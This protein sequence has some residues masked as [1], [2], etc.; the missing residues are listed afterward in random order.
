VFYPNDFINV[1]EVVL[2]HQLNYV[3]NVQSDPKFAK[4]KGLLDVCANFVETN[5]C[6]TFAM[7]YKL[8]KLVLL[9]PLATASVEIFFPDLKVVKSNL[10]NKMG[11]KWLNDRLVYI[12]RDVLLTINNDVILTH[13]QQMDR[14]RFSL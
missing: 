7:I 1:L 3:T 5:K 4:M 11:D 14:R 8:L 6:N 13:F 10:Y 9:L 12:E 2:R